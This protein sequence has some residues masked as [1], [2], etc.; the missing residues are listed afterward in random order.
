MRDGMNPTP[1]SGQ[2][3]VVQ[4]DDPA[5]FPEEIREKTTLDALGAPLVLRPEACL[6]DGQIQVRQQNRPPHAH[7]YLRS[8]AAS[9]ARHGRAE[10]EAERSS[11]PGEIHRVCRTR[12]GKSYRRKWI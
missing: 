8:L 4:A 5:E 12:Y 10:E 3:M 6:G 11:Q 9:L 1:V 7:R 2:I